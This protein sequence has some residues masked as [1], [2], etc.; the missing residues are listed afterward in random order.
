MTVKKSLI[1]AIK[2]LDVIIDTHMTAVA[3]ARIKKQDLIEHLQSTCDHHNIEEET[4]Y[5]EGTYYDKA[6]STITTRCITCGKVISVA[7]TNHSWYG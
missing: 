7:N 5:H 6:H 2:K 4:A 1:T 3:K